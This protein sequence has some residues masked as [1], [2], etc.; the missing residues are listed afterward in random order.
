MPLNL[1]SDVSSIAQSVQDDA[2]FIV[3]EGAQMQGLVTVFSDMSGLNT[4]KGYKYNSG[5]ATAVAESDDLTSKAFT[6]SADQTLTPAE[7]GLQFFIT[8]SRAESQ[9]PEQ[10]LTDAS[11]ELGFA[12]L[13]KLETDLCGDMASLTGGTVGTAGS[14][15]TWGYLAAAIAQARYVNK[16][17]SVPLAAVVHEYQWA[18]LAK[19]ASIAGASVAAV[20]PNFQETITATGFVA[21]FMGVPIYKVFQ[22]VDANDDYKGGVFPRVALALD[23][24]RA[25]RVRPERDESRR[26]LE[27]NMSA[28]YAHGVWRP[29]RGIQFIFDASKP[30]S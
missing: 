29:E 10:I 14:T 6:P 4:R 24:R 27:L 20:A 28:V 2:I 12:A 19:N 8:D 22:A 1:Y 16:S 15:I 17:N 3:R 21:Q 7:I 5:T 30:T 23:W 13:D 11:R 25:I 18:V 26:G 9:I